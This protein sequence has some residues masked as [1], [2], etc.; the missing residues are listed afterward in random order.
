[1]KK[2]EEK[3]KSIGFEIVKFVVAS[4]AS[5]GASTIVYTACKTLAPAPKSKLGKISLIAGAL[6]LSG[7]AG[8]AA[9]KQVEG[10][11]EIVHVF[12]GVC[13]GVKEAIAKS[14]EEKTDD[15]E[16]ETD[17]EEEPL[18]D[19][20]KEAWERVKSHLKDLENGDAQAED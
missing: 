15:G 5:S 12:K 4:V 13:K 3:K 18:T 7:A 11:F 8:T 1:M 6:A 10:D 17:E 20:D 2:N 16:E 14:K 19:A 9:W